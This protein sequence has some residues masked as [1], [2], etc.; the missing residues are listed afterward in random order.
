MLLLFLS[1]FQFTHDLLKQSEFLYYRGHT[2]RPRIHRI[3]QIEEYVLDIVQ[4]SLL[5]SIRNIS[6]QNDDTSQLTVWIIFNLSR[7]N[8]QDH[9]QSV[10]TLL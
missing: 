4:K 9:R 5:I 1:Y 8:A 7:I 2:G 3:T 10:P 6:E